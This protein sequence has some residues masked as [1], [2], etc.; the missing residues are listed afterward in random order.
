MNKY[1]KDIYQCIQWLE[2][3]GIIIYPTD[4]IWGI[5]CDATQ[6]QAIEKIYNIKRR[7]PTQSMLIL[8]SGIEMVRE[9]VTELPEK[10]I[11]LMEVQEKPV[12]LIYPHARSLPEN[13]V[14]NDGSIGI[15]IPKDDFC[16]HL[17]AR[18]G[19][20]IVS[21]S[22]NFS[23]K[24]FPSS[25]LEIDTLLLE[26]VDYVVKWRQNDYSPTR[27]SSIY[28]VTQEGALLTIRE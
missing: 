16:L 4:T 17:I 6:P 9:Y 28:K 26:Q 25:F 27:P 20:P 5:G 11:S 22:A 21:T 1:S 24:P 15:R 19:K 2:K 10:A 14:A 23:G 12:T 7:D 13:L 18:F 8:A 3:G